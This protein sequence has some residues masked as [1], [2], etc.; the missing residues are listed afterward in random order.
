[1]SVQQHLREIVVADVCER[2]HYSPEQANAI[3]DCLLEM[4]QM[5]D[6]NLILFINAYRRALERRDVHR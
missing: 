3:V 2:H 6:D 1:M 4:P 5:T